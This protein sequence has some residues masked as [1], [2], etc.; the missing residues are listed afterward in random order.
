MP[1]Q[2]LHEPPQPAARS[3]HFA[4]AWAAPPV[5]REDAAAA[6]TG[7]AQ[8]ARGADEPG[9]KRPMLPPWQRPGRYR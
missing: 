3:Q 6:T 5:P 4:P 8:R 1:T 9:R 7:G 2:S